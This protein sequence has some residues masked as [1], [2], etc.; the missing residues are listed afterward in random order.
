MY[1]ILKEWLPSEKIKEKT[2]ESPEK[3][4]GTFLEALNKVS[5]INTEI[6]LSRVSGMEKMYLETL[7][8]FN[9]KLENECDAMS[10]KINSGDIKSFSIAVHAMKSALSTIGAMG[11]SETASKL[12]TASK[13]D[14]IEYCRER[15]PA[16]RDKL[17][18]LHKELSGVFP[19]SEAGEAGAKKKSGDLS[20]LQVNIEKA[21]AAAS[22]FDGDAGLNVINDLLSFDF[23]ER[24]NALLEDAAAAFRDFNYEAAVE[25]LSKV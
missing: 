3:I 16:F 8:L 13:N 6:G 20:Y 15:F 9:K 17:L 25:L 24:N 18:N 23:G 22:D 14:D 10:S 5:E 1:G 4:S 21:L 7:E 12:E 2:E 19:Q 11:L